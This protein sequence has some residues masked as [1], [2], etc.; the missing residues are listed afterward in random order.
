MWREECHARAFGGCSY[1]HDLSE[2]LGITT[3]NRPSYRSPPKNSDRSKLISLT[4]GGPPTSGPSLDA[5]SHPWARTNSVFSMD[6]VFLNKI[7][8]AGQSRSPDL[9][10]SISR[11][12]G[13]RALQ[14]LHAFA[15]LRPQY[16]SKCSSVCFCVLNIRH[17]QEKRFFSN[18]VAIFA[19]III[20]WNLLGFSQIL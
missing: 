11:G 10:I 7:R 9:T 17:S 5:S 8:S 19:D 3:K 20:Q 15:P 6:H 4:I 1:F 14:D 13:G 16:F 12:R 18:F 2:A